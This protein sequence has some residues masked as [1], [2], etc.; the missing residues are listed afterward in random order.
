M[1]PFF[2]ALIAVAWMAFLPGLFLLRDHIHRKN[3]PRD[4]HGPAE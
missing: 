4:A 3:T 1:S 2:A